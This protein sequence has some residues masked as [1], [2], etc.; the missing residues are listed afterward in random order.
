[1][2]L[3]HAPSTAATIGRKAMNEAAPRV[4]DLVDASLATLSPN[5]A[6]RI[7]EQIWCDIYQDPS[8]S[9][10]D[11]ALATIAA[12]DSVGAGLDT[13]RCGIHHVFHR[14]EGASS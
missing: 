14:T 4:P 5:T 6:R 11:R 13:S 7:Y 8:L 9:L 2:T 10:R 3:T 1:M 12:D